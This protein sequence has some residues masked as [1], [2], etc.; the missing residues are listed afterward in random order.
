[1]PPVELR[2]PEAEAVEQRTPPVLYGV[3]AQFD[4]VTDLLAAA[5]E[6]R[7]AGYKRW[8]SYTPFPVH[9]LDRAMGMPATRLPWI[10]LAAGLT[11]LL[12]G[13][14]LVWWTN[15][16]NYPWVISGKPIFSLPANIPIIFETTVLFSAF[17]AVFGMLILNVLPRL[18]HPLFASVRFRRST[19][20]RFFIAIEADDPCFDTVETVELLHRVGATAVEEVAD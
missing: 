14:G 13:L 11:G 20:D 7:Q 19:N 5:R 9:G 10:V 18:H 6:V 17:G 1:M 16:V 2:E 15:A 8:E 3:L 4:S 12:G